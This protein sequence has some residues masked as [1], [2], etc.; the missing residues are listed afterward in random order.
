MIT[1]SEMEGETWKMLRTRG[2]LDDDLLD[3]IQMC[4]YEKMKPVVGAEQLAAL[5]GRYKVL[6]K[7]KQTHAKPL[8]TPPWQAMG[9]RTAPFSKRS[10]Q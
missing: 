5:R 1:G 8:C 2:N 4:Y 9:K 10:P 7:T 3:S 6:R